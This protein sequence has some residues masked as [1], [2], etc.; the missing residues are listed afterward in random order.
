MRGIVSDHI[1]ERD[2]TQLIAI[3]P[4]SRAGRHLDW[5]RDSKRSAY[6]ARNE[7]TRRIYEALRT[8]ETVMAVES[9][10]QAMR[11]KG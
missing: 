8:Q 5:C 6:F 9:A 10:A 3:V 2:E 1:I 7:I 11:D 4:A